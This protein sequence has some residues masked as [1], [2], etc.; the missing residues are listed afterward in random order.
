MLKY[1]FSIFFSVILV[2]N[3]QDF[4][5]KA[6]GTQT[7]NFDDNYGRNQVTFFSKTLL[8]DITGV[9]NQIKGNVTFEIGN[10]AKTLK[11]SF[12]VPVKSIKTGIT[13]R[14]EHLAGEEWL[15]S[16][17]YPDITFEIKKVN[18]VVE[19]KDNRLV[20]SVNGEITIKGVKKDVNGNFTLVYLDENEQT[21]KRAPGDLLNVRG[22]FNLKLSDFNITHQAIPSKVSNEIDVEVNIVGNNK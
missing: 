11:G 3:A 16:E 14:D 5:V 1:I 6:K 15:N 21:K 18:K 10:V 2:L 8:E 7:F 19:K 20:L 9:S 4:K 17:K 22:K 13:L 12:S